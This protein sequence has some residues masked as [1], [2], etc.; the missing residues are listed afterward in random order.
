MLETLA[1]TL[2][3][4]LSA[5]LPC[6]FF[7]QRSIGWESIPNME[8]HTDGSEFDSRSSLATSTGIR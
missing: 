6:F 8:I 7:Y 3:L 1:H 2:Q 4:V 5:E